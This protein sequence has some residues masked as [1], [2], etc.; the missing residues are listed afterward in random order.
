MRT[1]GVQ[2]NLKMGY[3][4]FWSLKMAIGD[5]QESKTVSKKFVEGP[6]RRPR[7]PKGDEKGTGAPLFG[8]SGG[9]KMDPN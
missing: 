8:V 9:R 2:M 5:L 1:E 3:G 6:K 7:E 4:T